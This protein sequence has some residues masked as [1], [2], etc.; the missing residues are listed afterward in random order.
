MKSII[1]LIQGKDKKLRESYA[2]KEYR[3]IEKVLVDLED[4][5]RVIK[6]QL[7]EINYLLGLIDK[8]NIDA[9]PLGDGDIDSSSTERIND[10]K[11][12]FE[13]YHSKKYDE[14]SVDDMEFLRT[15]KSKLI[16]ER[17]RLN[18]DNK[19]INGIIAKTNAF[20]MDVRDQLCKEYTKGETIDEVGLKL[21][22]H[23]KDE[24]NSETTYEMG[25]NKI[26]G[27]LEDTYSIN[28]VHAK[29]LFD[30]LEQSK[31]VDYVI[32]TSNFYVFPNY[33][34]FADFTNI[35]YAPLF[36]TWKINA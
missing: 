16:Q 14:L 23:F 18:M 21:K 25:W 34:D 29:K 30:I 27:F 15:E 11:I 5:H 9:V 13:K 3:N 17:D 31:V 32:D 24:F 26:I 33:E 20:L 8:H 7:R 6:D 36:G 19:H 22:E 28:R 35:N 12:A 1:K 2:K 10:L 4:Q